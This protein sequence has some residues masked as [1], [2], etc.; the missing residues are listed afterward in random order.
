M[1]PQWQDPDLRGSHAQQQS[2]DNALRPLLLVD[3]T[4]ERPWQQGG[5]EG[6]WEGDPVMGEGGARMRPP[7][8]HASSRRHHAVNQPETRTGGSTRTEA[9]AIQPLQGAYEQQARGWDSQH[10]AA[11]PPSHRLALERSRPREGEEG[12]GTCE[13]A[14]RI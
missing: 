7:S 5:R 12:G 2:G 9:S 10:K 6:A 11:S 13:A 4:E 14:V 1:L 3:A 8:P